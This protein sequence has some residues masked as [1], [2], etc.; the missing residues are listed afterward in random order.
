[1][2]ANSVWGF[3]SLG[4]SFAL[5]RLS[6]LWTT[7]H[8]ELAHFSTYSAIACFLFCG[9]TAVWPVG[10]RFFGMGKLRSALR[11]EIGHDDRYVESKSYNIYNVM[12]TVSVGIKNT[13]DSY[14][15]NCKVTYSTRDSNDSGKV[16]GWHR[17]GPFTLNPGEERYLSLAAYNEPIPPH[18]VGVAERIR[19]SA[20]PSGSF[21]HPPTLH[22]HG[23]LVTIRVESKEIPPCEENCRIWTVEGILH[24]EKV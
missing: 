3:L 8:E 9:L 2:W 10:V 4:I 7:G 12:K 5:F 6:M 17:D 19:L 21:W 18:P 22:A 24:W 11:I 15:S 13:G 16:D 23:G 1:M 20:P 14:I